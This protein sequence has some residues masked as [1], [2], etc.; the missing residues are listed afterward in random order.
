MLNGD[1][2]GYSRLMAANEEASIDMLAAH[3]DSIGITVVANHG[4]LIDFT[5]DN[6]LAEFG[7]A[8]H[9]LRCAIEIQHAIHT[10]YSDTLPA[11]RLNFRLGAHLGDVR[12][13]GE[14][15]YG[16]AVN[17]ASRLESLSEAGGICLSRQIL[18]QVSGQID[19]D[20]EDLGEQMLKNIPHAVHA[21]RIS[22]KSLMSEASTKYKQ[23]HNGIHTSLTT[24]G[25]PTIAVLPFAN[26]STDP[27]HAYL[28]D[29]MTAD[30]ISG[31]SCDQR[32]SVISHNAV[33]RFSGNVADIRDVG[34]VLRVRYVVEGTLRHIGSRIRV[35]MALI[36]VESRTEL[37]GDK[38]DRP[39][40]DIFD[41]F[42]ELVEAIVT[43][44]GSHLKLA[45]EDRFR[46]KPPEQ[47][48]AWALAS[49]AWATFFRNPS[50]TL[51]D[52]LNLVRRALEIDPQYAYA[53]AV[54]GFLTALKFPLGLSEDHQA[55][56]D[57]SLRLTDKALTL[58]LGDPWC[59]VAK[60]VALQYGGRAAESM[61]YLQH[62]LRLNPS[63][64]VAHCYYGRALMFSGRPALAHAHFE[65]FK[66]LN[67]D[68]PGAHMALMYHTIA[69]V[70][71]QRWQEAV[72]VARDGIAA[73]GGRNG[74]TW[75]LLMLALGG[76]GKPDDA[77]AVIPEINKVTPHWDRKFVE[78][79]LDECQEDKA[80]LRPILEI[81]QSV[82]P[83]E[84][85]R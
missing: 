50:T 72:E 82:W 73:A 84:D 1:I 77:A 20:F 43:A 62:S 85:E 27:E 67:P 47:L 41:V 37:W 12:I 42:D 14:R 38:I 11:Q 76:Q 39:L 3:R 33:T 31:L 54:L 55:D 40:T 79:F 23:T 16:D 69:L 53:W 8:V 35:S 81:L 17:I 71:M 21:Y 28:A 30:I 9:A 26:L 48:D 7:S 83:D 63:D 5:G 29:G 36:D 60:A 80:L 32:F 6:F 68:D 10:K 58:D 2:A 70:F 74:W 19:I 25:A 75:V 56:V 61:E 24:K 13:E 52:S 44:L 78:N 18:D 15:I 57:E 51:D 65:R 64:V 4:R 66:R 45:E 22:A 49:R 34:E 59:L 46:R